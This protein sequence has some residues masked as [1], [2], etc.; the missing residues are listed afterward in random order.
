MITI[1]VGICRSALLP[2]EVLP[3]MLP[4]TFNHTAVLLGRI[5]QWYIL[6]KLPPG[7]VTGFFSSSHHL[8]LCEVCVALPNSFMV[9]SLAPFS[10]FHRCSMFSAVSEW[11]RYQMFSFPSLSLHPT[12][13]LLS[14]KAPQSHHLCMALPC[15][16]KFG[17]RSLPAIL[18]C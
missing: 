16:W 3:Q 18:Y 10:G 8:L 4:P 13:P 12:F 14:W 5:H 1:S 11:G 2:K 17:Y 15:E 7:S 9:Y 6:S